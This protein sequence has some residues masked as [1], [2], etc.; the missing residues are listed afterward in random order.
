MEAGRDAR[1]GAR[2]AG[3]AA[4]WRWGERVHGEGATAWR[5]D[6]RAE[7]GAVAR[8]LQ[9]CDVRDAG[10]GM[11]GHGGMALKKW[12]RRRSGGRGERG[13]RGMGSARAEEGHSLGRDRRHTVGGHSSGVGTGRDTRA[14]SMQRRGWM[15]RA[16]Q[17]GRGQGCR[18]GQC[19]CR[20]WGGSR[21]RGS[22]VGRDGTGD[23]RAEWTQR[24]GGTE[25][26]WQ[27]TGWVVCTWAGRV[28][29]GG[30]R[31]CPVV[32]VGGARGVWEAGRA[33][34]GGGHDATGK[35]R[36]GWAHGVLEVGARAGTRGDVAQAPAQ[37]QAQAG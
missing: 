32:E 21:R 9:G 33:S 1:G 20:C 22:S 7:Q 23:G 10:R 19:R 11:G 31:A 29:G 16:R 14:E 12:A 6:G 8:G 3:V 30:V 17:R 24:R 18:G 4:V 28:G 36:C 26:T 35:D 27:R 15:G 25:R 2:E 37:A 13:C 5:Q 34:I